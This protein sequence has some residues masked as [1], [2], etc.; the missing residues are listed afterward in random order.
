MRP[1]QSVAKSVLLSLALS[2]GFNLAVL[3]L[4]IRVRQC[5]WMM[6]LLVP[7]IKASLLFAP[8]FQSVARTSEAGFAKMARLLMLMASLDCVFYGA[9][10]FAILRFWRSNRSQAAEGKPQ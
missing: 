5:K 3:E 7:G 9:L 2:I 8:F 4:G 6:I 10:F 1:G